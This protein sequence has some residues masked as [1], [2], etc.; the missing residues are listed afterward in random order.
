MEGSAMNS[1]EAH[2]LEIRLLRNLLVNIVVPDK[3]V[4]PRIDKAA[5]KSILELAKG[6]MKD[7]MYALSMLSSVKSGLIAGIH[8]DKSRVAAQL[9]KRIKI[10]PSTLIPKG[11][12]CILRAFVRC[13]SNISDYFPSPPAAHSEEA[14]ARALPCRR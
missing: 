3:I 6:K 9:A 10:A 8:S 13:G 4:D 2:K 12:R 14:W 1:I 11:P 7:R 5:Q